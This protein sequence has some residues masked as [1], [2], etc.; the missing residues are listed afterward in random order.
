MVA[1]YSACMFV[2]HLGLVVLAS[3]QAAETNALKLLD[4]RTHLGTPLKMCADISLH[5]SSWIPLSACAGQVRTSS[6]FP[7]TP[8]ATLL[9]HHSDLVDLHLLCL[10]NA[11]CH[12]HV[13]CQVQMGSGGNIAHA[14]HL[15]GAAV[16]AA[17]FL[18]L[19]RGRL[20]W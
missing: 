20:R 16:G 17:A 8:T 18:L 15:G 7:P 1:Y 6:S 13:Y 3:S 12:Q 19:R 2:C 4:C 9:L 11:W 5:V 14:G 10:C